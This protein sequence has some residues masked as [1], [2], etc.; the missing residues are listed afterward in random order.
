M[1][2]MRDIPETPLRTG[3]A[4]TGT[5]YRVV[6]TP[7]KLILCRNFR[8]MIGGLFL[9]LLAYIIPVAAGA[10]LAQWGISIPREVNKARRRTN[11]IGTAL[12]FQNQT[13]CSAGAQYMANGGP[14]TDE[15]L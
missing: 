9:L 7:T 8:N 4:E 1:R 14:G 11:S 6:T 3:N 12:S 13:T 2:D 5:N 15:G 10:F